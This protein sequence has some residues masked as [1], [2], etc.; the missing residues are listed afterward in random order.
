MATPAKWKELEEKTKAEKKILCKHFDGQV[1][2]TGI[3]IARWRRFFSKTQQKIKY[4]PQRKLWPL[5]KTAKESDTVAPN[6]WILA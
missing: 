3:Y 6:M 4:L 1:V 5:H 2:L